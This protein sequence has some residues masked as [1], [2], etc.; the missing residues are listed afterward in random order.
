MQKPKIAFIDDEPRIL[1]SLKMHFRQS[2]DVFTTT[3]ATE[4]MKYVSE[5]DVQVV[6][7]DQRMPDKQGTEVLRDIKEASPN[8]I[9]ILLTGY[10]DLNA[11]IDSVN[12][13]EIYRYITKPW[14]NDELKKIVNKATEIAQQTQD[15]T[16]N[17]KQGDESQSFMNASSKRNILVLDDDESIYQEIKNQFKSTYTVSW[18][19]NLEQAA[20]LLQKKKFGVTITDATLNEE[21][22]TP[23]VYALKNIQPDLMV[24]MLTEFKDAHMVIDL[25]NKG[26]V[27]RC[28]PRPT[29]FSIMSISLD[30]AFEHH[31][32]LVQQPILA[33]RHHVEEVPEAETFNFSERLK[34]FFAK[35]RGW[36]MMM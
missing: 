25:I 35:F 9:R 34:G 21:N 22:I 18:A 27:Y 2:H 26:Q 6:I 5:H 29:N 32:R 14:Q 23:I 11:V 1:R 30:R 16:Q 4:L 12:D 19:S 36:R 17:M 31:E 13:G 28:L 24:L 3:D 10:A 7:S 15:I 20:K 33:T 8:T